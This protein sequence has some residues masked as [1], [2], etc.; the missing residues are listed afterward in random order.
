MVFIIVLMV[1]IVSF[2]I[3]DL[4]GDF[5]SKTLKQLTNLAPTGNQRHLNYFNAGVCL[6]SLQVYY[7]YFLDMD[8]GM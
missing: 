7:A 8:I 5:I 2:T 1:C 4:S 3:I 6:L